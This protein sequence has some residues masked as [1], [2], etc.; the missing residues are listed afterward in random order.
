MVLISEM[1]CALITIRI[2]ELENE[3]EYI[4]MISNKWNIQTVL[5]DSTGPVEISGIIVRWETGGN[6][7]FY[8]YK[9]VLTDR[10]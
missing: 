10:L 4:S 9:G 7:S 8:N 6:V 2:G 5:F 3:V 1:G